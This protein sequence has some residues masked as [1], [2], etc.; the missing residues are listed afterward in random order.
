MLARLIALSLVTAGVV[1]TGALAAHAGNDPKKLALRASDF[2]AKAERTHQQASGSA[3]LPGGL[4]GAAYAATYTF[5]S[6]PKREI[7]FQLV[8]VAKSESHARAVYAAAVKEAKE[9]NQPLQHSALRLPAYGDQQSATLLGDVAAE[10]TQTQMWVR[11]KSVVWQLMIFTDPTEKDSGFS[12]TQA[13]AELA[14][15]A[16]KLKARVGNPA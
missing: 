9:M 13:L 2:P 6:G 3:S 14:K 16:G 5:P 11:R 12:K 8:V 4:R 7:V 15:Y 1:T 10:E